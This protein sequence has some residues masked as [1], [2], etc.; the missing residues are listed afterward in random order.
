MVCGDSLTHQDFAGIIYLII[1]YRTQN[2]K[3]TTN[4]RQSLKGYKIKD[5]TVSKIEP[6][7]P[8]VLCSFDGLSYDFENFIF[9]SLSSVSSTMFIL[10]L[11]PLWSTIT[12]SL[13]DSLSSSSFI[14]FWYVIS[15]SSSWWQDQMQQQF[16]LVVSLNLHILSPSSPKSSILVASPSNLLHLINIS[17][18]AVASVDLLALLP[19][20]FRVIHSDDT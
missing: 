10:G 19:P 8:P 11:N 17:N 16:Y 2:N 7:T 18:L 20:R 1:H 13:L 9:S 6:N 14:A 5:V 15:S 3:S 12:K 4:V